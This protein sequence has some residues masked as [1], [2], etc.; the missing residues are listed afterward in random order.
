[1]AAVFLVMGSWIPLASLHTR[2]VKH[3]PALFR[4][5]RRPR[6]MGGPFSR[7]T[8]L[9][10]G[11]LLIGRPGPVPSDIR[12]ATWAFRGLLAGAAVLLTAP[13]WFAT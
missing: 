8:W 4:R 10:A 1:M 11:F 9:F 12:K 2:L 7:S 3:H 5:L 6:Y 13:R